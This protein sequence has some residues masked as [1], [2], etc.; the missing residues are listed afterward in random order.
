MLME[1][2]IWFMRQLVTMRTVVEDPFSPTVESI[3]DSESGFTAVTPHFPLLPPAPP[4]DDLKL[5][6]TKPMA[7]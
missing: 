1:L 7:L 6:L 5:P 4:T 3:V 2:Q